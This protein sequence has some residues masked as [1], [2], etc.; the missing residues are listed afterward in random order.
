MICIII[1]D[2][3]QQCLY[4]SISV[5]C[6]YL[7]MSVQFFTVTI[8]SELWSTRIQLAAKTQSLYTQVNHSFKMCSLSS[9]TSLIQYSYFIHINTLQLCMCVYLCVPCTI[10]WHLIMMTDTVL[11]I[12][13][14]I[15]HIYVYT[16]KGRKSAPLSACLHY[17]IYLS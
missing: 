13:W 5:V 6:M 17:I 10:N 8:P 14:Y 15:F 12:Q 9:G 2:T 16:W 11:H 3:F 1:Q 4:L 7:F